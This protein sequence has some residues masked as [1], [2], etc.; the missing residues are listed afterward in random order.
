MG[1]Y[2]GYLC[3]TDRYMVDILGYLRDIWGTSL[4]LWEISG[5]HMGISG[6]DLQHTGSTGSME[7]N[8]FNR[9]GV[10]GAV[11]QTPLLLFNSFSH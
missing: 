3:I 5:G 1:I 7:P 2:V 6:R 4:D 9:P 8:F 11:L 10:A